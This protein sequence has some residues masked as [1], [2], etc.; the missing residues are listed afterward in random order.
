MVGESIKNKILESLE[1]EL[2]NDT[3]F[4]SSI[5]EEKVNN[6]LQEVIDVRKY[7]VNYTDD[8]KESDLSR[9]YSKIRNIALYD[10]NMAGAEFQQT[11]SENGISRTFV[12]REK[13]FSGII[14]IARF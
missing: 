10:Y 2:S 11:H 5:L 1:S 13:L 12:A 14:P 9:F 7:P 8:M 6:A 4:N 3:G